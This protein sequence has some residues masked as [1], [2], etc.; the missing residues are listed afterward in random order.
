MTRSRELVGGSC[1]LCSLRDIR[2]HV[3]TL[4]VLVLVA[5]RERI[6][7]FLRS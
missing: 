7:L 3:A 4:C 5:M 6:A 1:E 2:E